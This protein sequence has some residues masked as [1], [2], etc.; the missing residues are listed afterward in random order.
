MRSAKLV[1]SGLLALVATV[2]CGGAPSPTASTA[3]AKVGEATTDP[4]S[5]A[6]PSASADAQ[7]ATSATPTATTGAVAS[8]KPADSA[9][10]SEPAAV[11]KEPNALVLE[12]TFVMRGGGKV[13][14]DTVAELQK[15]FTAGVNA[16][17][18]LALA[19]SGAPAARS[20]VATFLLDTPTTDAKGLTVKMSFTGIES[21]GKCPVFDLNQNLTMSGGKNTPADVLELQKAAVASLLKKLEPTAATLKPKANCTATK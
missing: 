6:A 15:A 10:P 20:V 14:P 13:A 21:V 9:K 4:A 8:A 17:P 11:A 5:T 1:I 12:P 18:K 7:A 2:A 3:E 16:S 19:G